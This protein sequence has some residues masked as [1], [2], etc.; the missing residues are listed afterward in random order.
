MDDTMESKVF[1]QRTPYDLAWQIAF[2]YSAFQARFDFAVC[3]RFRKQSGA[4]HY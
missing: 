2:D 3:L 4:G 1:S